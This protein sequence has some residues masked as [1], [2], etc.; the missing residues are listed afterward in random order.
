M[1][2]VGDW[3]ECTR[4]SLLR[5]DPAALKFVG[6]C[7]DLAPVFATASVY[8]HPG[9]GDAFP[10]SVLE[11]MAAGLVPIVSEWTGA[12]EVVEQVDPTASFVLLTRARLPSASSIS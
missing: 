8:L 5:T 7:S 10:L 12:K 4:E 9:R 6:R 3:D 11:A 2:I 1:T